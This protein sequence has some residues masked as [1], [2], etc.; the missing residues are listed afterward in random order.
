M[1]KPLI[2]KFVAKAAPVPAPSCDTVVANN[3]EDPPPAAVITPAPLQVP[4]KEAVPLPLQQALKK[5][6]L[7]K[8]TQATPLPKRT[9]RGPPRARGPRVD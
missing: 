9:F 5:P 4:A 2:C 1:A 7:E 3:V 6:A 8:Q